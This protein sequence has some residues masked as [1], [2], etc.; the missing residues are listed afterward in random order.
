MRITAWIVTAEESFVAR[1]GAPF[2][3]PAVRMLA[4]KFAKNVIE[5]NKGQLPDLLASKTD[6]TIVL[7]LDCAMPLLEVCDVAALLEAVVAGGASRAYVEGQ[8]EDAMPFCI[9][10]TKGPV[11][12]IALPSE[13]LE[14]VTDN[15]KLVEAIGVLH[16]RKRDSLL[17]EGVVLL[18]P[19]S[20]YVDMDVFIGE[21]TVIHGGCTLQRGTRI[22]KNC[23]ILPHARLEAATI[24]NGVRIEQSVIVSAS[25]GDRTSVG[26]FAYIRPGTK[27]GTDCRVGDFVEIKNST[28]ASGTMVSHLAYVGDADVGERVNLGC[29]IVFVNYDGKE[30]HRTQ[31][32]DDAFVGCNVNLVS[33]VS[34]GSGSYIAAGSTVTDT[35]PDGAFAIARQRQV[36]KDGWVAKRKAEG[37]L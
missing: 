30:K 13:N 17:D 28:I 19:A 20:T 1:I 24:G 7:V 35:V 31:V 29:G 18:D 23:E 27:I 9:G 10:N 22:G 25:V 12:A 5:V 2:L 26:P 14:S 4:G 6:D 3:L 11:T 15:R 37:K 34:V 8:S 33:P 36:V 21:G 16:A 32:G